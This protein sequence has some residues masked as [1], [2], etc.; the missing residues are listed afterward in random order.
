MVNSNSRTAPS[1]VTSDYRQ[2]Q[3]KMW[4]APDQENEQNRQILQQQQEQ[5]QQQRLLAEQ[6]KKRQEEID[7]QLK[8]QRE[9]IQQ[10]EAAKREKQERER[11]EQ[12]LKER[13]L[14]EQIMAAEQALTEERE[15]LQQREQERLEAEQKA[16]HEARIKEIEIGRQRRAVI[17][18]QVKKRLANQLAAA[19]VKETVSRT[20][21][22]MHRRH[23]LA[24][25]H[26]KDWLRRARQRIQARHL[27][28]HERIQQHRFS[29]FFGSRGDDTSSYHT[30]RLWNDPST[31]SAARLDEVIHEKA[32]LS[33]DLE[34]S[35]L[36]SYNVSWKVKV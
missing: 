10:Y 6:V 14:A 13:Q 32:S 22:A 21:K 36:V 23:D 16:R 26:T 15:R 28:R 25:R 20:I 7:I 3:Q 31:N 12:E 24:K 33:L 2:Q 19:V 1:K 35:A 34:A 8:A 27:K 30:P 17:Q 5:Q 29:T 18:S 4:Q 9:K 11:M